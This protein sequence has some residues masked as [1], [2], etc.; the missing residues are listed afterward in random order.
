MLKFDPWRWR[1]AALGLLVLLVASVIFLTNG[2]RA[3]LTW[4]EVI[5][6]ETIAPLQSGVAIVSTGVNKAVT[7][8][9][10]LTRL[11]SENAKLREEVETLRSDLAIAMEAQRENESLREMMALGRDLRQQVTVA[12]VIARNPSNWFNTLTIGKGAS[13]GIIKD[14][15]VVTKDGVVGR[16]FT[17]TPHTA[18]VLLITDTRS[19]VGGRLFRTNAVVLAEG[20]GTPGY[21]RVNVRPLDQET[22][23][24]A[25]D[26]IV[27]SGL[28]EIFPKGLRLGVVEEVYDVR[29]GLTRYGLL[30]PAV[31]F[32]SLEWVAVITGR[33]K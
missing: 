1:W 22:D 16:I 25:G 3:R 13:S 33:S 32:S 27:T 29:H 14:M 2:Q 26:I 5:L 7:S 6:R 18:E 9:T 10:Q 31:N 28:S 11:A 21:G 8:V 24:R 4:P 20:A 17:V 30:R 23:I 19:A 15:P 12:E